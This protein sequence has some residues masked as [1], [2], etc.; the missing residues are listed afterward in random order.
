MHRPEKFR[1]IPVSL[2][3]ERPEVLQ[4]LFTSIEQ[5]PVTTR[6]E[7][8][9]LIRPQV[10]AV[11]ARGPQLV[12]GDVPPEAPKAA[13]TESRSGTR[14]AGGGT[15]NSVGADLHLAD[16]RGA[17]VEFRPGPL[18]GFPVVLPA[19]TSISIGVKVGVPVEARVGDSFDV[20]LIQRNTD[21]AV[22][23]GI[24]IRVNVIE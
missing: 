20:D 13:A 6:P 12:V 8:V 19:R 11:I 18:S 2:V 23:G 24:R 21:G 3:S 22:V 1:A 7:L 15:A 17:A 10:E 14:R 9:G 4:K 16:L 5:V